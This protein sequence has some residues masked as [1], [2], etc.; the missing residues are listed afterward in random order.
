M[1]TKTK[2]I[3]AYGPKIKVRL[4]FPEPTRTHQSAKDEC[5]INKIMAKYV[6]T[7]VLDHQEEYGENYGFCTSMDL[8]EALSTVRTANEMFAELPAEVR[9]KFD[10]D[11]GAFLDFTLDPENKAELIEM[12]LA[13]EELSDQVVDK[14]PVEPVKN[15]VVEPV[16]EPPTAE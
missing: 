2:F 6:K 15:P 4:S 16:V 11:P 10:H 14:K 13:K 8:L 1:E 5:D 3:T 9:K 12:G 7:G